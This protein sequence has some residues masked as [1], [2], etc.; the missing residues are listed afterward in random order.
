[1]IRSRNACYN[2]SGIRYPTEAGCVV[3]N[4]INAHEARRHFGKLLDTIQECH[5]AVVIERH[6]QP[7]A[8][9]V[10]LSI[11]QQWQRNAAEARETYNAIMQR[12]A[13][14]ADL[15][16]TEAAEIAAEAVAWARGNATSTEAPEVA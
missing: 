2:R 7:A 3:E 11:Y 8:V 10:P 1:M 14:Q 16:E 9:M 5:E 15:G 13:E 12:A 6:G 4:T